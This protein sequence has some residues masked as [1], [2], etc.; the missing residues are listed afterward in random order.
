[1]EEKGGAAA[2]VSVLIAK[3][4]LAG[5]WRENA[6]WYHLDAADR[7]GAEHLAFRHLRQRP[8]RR[9]SAKRH[10]PCDDL[11]R[12]HHLDRA[13]A[14]EANTWTSVTYGN[15][16]FVAVA[17]GGTHQVMTS[18]DGMTWTAQTA[19]EASSWLAVTYGNGIFVA[20]AQSG[21][22][23]VMTTAAIACP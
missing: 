16:Q 10:A 20:V 11:A 19:A 17:L 6:R 1:M 12:R 9:G 21:T 4:K 14:A 13:T 3:V 8:V 22:H 7:G 2:A 23:L 15:G 18:P 5:M